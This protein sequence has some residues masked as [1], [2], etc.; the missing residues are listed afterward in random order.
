[1]DWLV[2]KLDH[3]LPEGHGG[4]RAFAR[5]GAAAPL[6]NG[7]LENASAARATARATA[8][9]RARARARAREIDERA[10]AIL[11]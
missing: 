5:E 8:R 3:M 4:P 1:M 9:T 11:G 2:R 10:Q 6:T 7:L